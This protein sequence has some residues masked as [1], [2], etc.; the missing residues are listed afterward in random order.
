MKLS[1]VK[2]HQFVKINELVLLKLP[3]GEFDLA[4]P[5]EKLKSGA[6]QL[7]VNVELATKEEFIEAVCK[8]DHKDDWYSLMLKEVMLKK[9]NSL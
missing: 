6:M 9:A 3:N 7:D 1:E 4:L 5:G 2:I 8:A